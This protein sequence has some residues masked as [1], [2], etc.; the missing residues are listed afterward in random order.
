M[1]CAMPFKDRFQ[2]ETLAGM[3]YQLLDLF[4]PRSPKDLVISKVQETLSEETRCPVCGT[5][6]SRGSVVRCSKCRSAHH[7][8]CWKFNGLCATFAC[9]GTTHVR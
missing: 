7:A 1:S 6:L 4:D 9:G 5:P 2:I 8:D 3:A